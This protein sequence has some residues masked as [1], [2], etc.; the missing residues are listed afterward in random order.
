MAEA[1]IDQAL[2]AAQ[3]RARE[4]ALYWGAGLDSYVG[5]ADGPR[6]R[7]AGDCFRE[8]ASRFGAPRRMVATACASGTQAIGE[9]FRLIRSGRSEA[10]L[11]GGSSIMLHPLYIA[12]FSALQALVPSREVLDD[13]PA[14]A[15]RP[16]DRKRR[17]LVLADGAAAIVLESL[18][19]AER[20]GVTPLA[21]VIGFGMS[22]DAY[23]LNRPP[24]DGHG[25]ELSMRRALA[26]ARLEPEELGAVNAHG[27][28]THAGDHAEAA[29]LR[30]LLGDAWP[31]TPVSSVKGGLGHAMAAA[32]PSKPSSPCG[33]P[34]RESPHRESLGS[35]R[36]LRARP[37]HGRAAEDGCNHGSL[38]VVRDGRPEREHRGPEV[39]GMNP[40][41]LPIVI[42]LARETLA[43][44]REI[45]VEPAH[46]LFYDLGFTSMD[47]LDFLFRV[48]ERFEIA[49][50]EGTLAGLAR[51][52]LPETEFEVDGE[53]TALGRER[54]MALLHDTPAAVF[55]ERIRTS[56]LPR[57]CTVAAI[58]R[59]VEHKRKAA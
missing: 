43:L 57:Y 14:G 31:R 18:G 49:I 6:Y 3:L 56:S 38:G 1:A 11:A 9:G 23:D 25:A 47:M 16:F 19:S 41:A 40:E 42:E 20:R 33:R 24:E 13:D 27:T 10:C 5:T 8:I 4:A 29:A 44:S 52:E 55:P 37:R 32:G 58:A 2:S 39:S 7:A 12:G 59:L 28:G 36:G 46:L 45:A 54:L 26:D 53:L 22:Q 34:P 17:G 48:E 21:E 30:R 50:P 35:R 51:G 15:C